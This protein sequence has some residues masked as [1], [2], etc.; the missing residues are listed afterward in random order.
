M[1]VITLVRVHVHGRHVGDRQQVV[2]GVVP[3]HV[4]QRRVHCLEA[5]LHGRAVHAF[6]DVLEQ[7]AVLRFAVAQRFLGSLA[8]DGDGRERRQAAHQ[9]EVAAERAARLLEIQRD[10]AEHVAVRCPHRRGPAGAQ[11]GFDGRRA[12]VL[13]ERVASD[14]GDDH[15]AVQED[16]GGARAVARADLDAPLGIEV[17]LRQAHAR[18]VLQR[19]GFRVVDRHRAERIRRYFLGRLREGLE[20]R[21]QVHVARDAL[22]HAPVTRGQQFAALALGD[23]GD[24]AADQAPARGGQ[25]DQAD[26][27]GDV[28][29]ECVAVQPLEPGCVAG[30]RTIEVP[31]CDAERRR[32]ILLE[33]RADLF[34]PD[35]QQLVA[36]HLEEAHGVLVAFDEQPGVH[37]EHDDGFR[38]V[39]D[40]RAIARLAFAD[41]R[42]G[43][44]AFGGFAHADDEELA[45][46]EPHLAH[47]DLGVEQVAVAVPALGLAGLEVV[48]GVLDGGRQFFERLDDAGAARQRRN[49]QVELLAAHVLFAVT[50]NPLAG[51]VQRFDAA[52]L[53][54]RDDRVLD[55]IEDD[56]QLGRGAFAHLAR[57]R[58]GLVRQQPH[59]THDALAFLVPLRVR[60]ADGVQ[61]LA[62]VELARRPRGSRRT[63]A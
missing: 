51:G 10:R 62:Q 2:D 3:E 16:R 55:V 22:E 60:L 50:E 43:Q 37:V 61:Q 33:R 27:A 46:V 36:R 5:A 28:V 44:L 20:R 26:L 56:L 42:F 23:V 58:A 40:Q 13:P 8:L 32:A 7:A 19:V 57:E 38:R 18:H 4:R 1:H 54:D 21:G 6:D 31:A 25:A 34:G 47:A 45:A 24:A 15:L 29:P 52:R 30:E 53:I 9:F 14:L 59:R 17:V 12:Q 11:S 39:F 48:V 35:A 41:R 63:A 49:Q